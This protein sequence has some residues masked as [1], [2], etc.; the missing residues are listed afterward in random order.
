MTRLCHGNLNT[1][2]ATRRND[3]CFLVGNEEI[4][5][6]REKRQLGLLVCDIFKIRN[7]ENLFEYPCDS[8]LINVVFLHNLRDGARRRMISKEALHKIVYV[9]HIMVIMLCF[10]SYMISKDAN[11]ALK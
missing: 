9:C 10:Q 6:V 8:K 11:P 5:F 2:I 3:S 7:A 4:A 1:R